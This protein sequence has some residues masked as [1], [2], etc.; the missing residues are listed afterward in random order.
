[1]NIDEAIEI[2]NNSHPISKEYN[3]AFETAID[4]MKFTR[5]FLPLCETPDRMKRAIN[6]LNSLEYAIE[7]VNHRDGH[8]YFTMDE[9]KLK[10]FG[11]SR[12]RIDLAIENTKKYIRD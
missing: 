8:V 1:M 12:E 2:L 10:E 4:C 7:A 3:E 5:D 6:L 11:A 9:G